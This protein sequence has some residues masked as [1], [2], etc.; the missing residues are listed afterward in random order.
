MSNT[1]TK[2][3]DAP[4]QHEAAASSQT[5]HDTKE[6][7]SYKSPDPIVEAE[8]ARN[9]RPL[10]QTM[11]YREPRQAMSRVDAVGGPQPSKVEKIMSDT[12][13]DAAALAECVEEVKAKRAGAEYDKANEA[14]LKAMQEEAAAAKKAAEEKKKEEDEIR[15]EAE[16]LLKKKKEEAKKEADK[17]KAA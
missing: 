3:H 1:T 13:E 5:K 11:D 7:T 16:E 15:K 2:S 8:K 10:G 14:R 12:K 17:T 4:K 6:E 9:E